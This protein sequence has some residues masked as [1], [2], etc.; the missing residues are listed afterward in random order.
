MAI[1]EEAIERDPAIALAVL[2][3]AGA[4]GGATRFTNR[5][6]ARQLEVARTREPR[7]GDPQPDVLRQRDAGRAGRAEGGQRVRG[8]ARDDD[9]IA[10]P[11]AREHLDHASGPTRAIDRR[12]RRGRD[13]DLDDVGDRNRRDVE[14]AV[15]RIGHEHAIDQHADRAF[16]RAADVDVEAAAAGIAYGDIGDQRERGREIGGAARGELLA[17]EPDLG[18]AI[19]R[20]VGA[21]VEDLDDVTVRELLQFLVGEALGRRRLE[22]GRAIWSRLRERRGGRP[23]GDGDRRNREQILGQAVHERKGEPS[24]TLAVDVAPR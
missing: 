14:R 18:V 2:Q 16:A 10:H 9:L 24:K 15:V 8:Q 7:A 17:G 19:E 5:G 21:L 23:P 20:L 13:A 11:V 6:V 12:L 4:G 1:V 3:A 22:G